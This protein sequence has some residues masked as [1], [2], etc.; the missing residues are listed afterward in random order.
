M[1]RDEGQYQLSHVFDDLLKKSSG[2]LF[3][4]QQSTRAVNSGLSLRHYV[5]KDGCKPLKRTQV[6]VLI[7]TSYEENL[8]CF[9]LN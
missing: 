8:L 7:W 2:N 5:D 1:N 4:M 6:S 3:A 9:V